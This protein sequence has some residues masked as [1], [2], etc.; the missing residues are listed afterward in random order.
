VVIVPQQDTDPIL[1]ALTAQGFRVT[2]ISSTGGF[3]RRGRA[4]LLIGVEGGQVDDVI[5]LLKETC[6]TLPGKK[7]KGPSPKAGEGETP[8][9][10]IALFVLGVENFQYV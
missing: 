6:R 10:E 2:L 1:N 3:L 7:R 9:C 4:T 5:R 8:P